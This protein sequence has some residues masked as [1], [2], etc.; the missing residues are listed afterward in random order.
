MINDDTIRPWKS[1]K[2]ETYPFGKQGWQAAQYMAGLIW[3]AVQSVV[4]KAAEAMQWLQSVAQIVSKE[5]LPINWTTPTGLLVQQ[6]YKL[7]KMKDIEVTF[8]KVRIRPKIDEGCD[9]L[10]SRKQA[11]GISPNWVHSLDASHMMR[12]ICASKL[13]GV[14]AFSFI[15]DSYGT[16]AGNTAFLAETLREEFV[17]M[18]SGCVLS[19]FREDLQAM[20]PEGI[21]LPPVPLKGSLDLEQVRESAFFFA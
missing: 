15:H 11:N 8:Q 6:A 1:K 9:K 21:E 14:E 4:V 19:T 5:A 12:T 20:L 18:Y 13:A 2:P 3:D 16:H 17:K 7:R 10:D